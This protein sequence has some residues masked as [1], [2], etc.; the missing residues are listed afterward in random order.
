MHRT[1]RRGV[2]RRGTSKP[3]PAK[4]IKKGLYLYY[5]TSWPNSTVDIFFIKSI[6]VSATSLSR[7]SHLCKAVEIRNM[8]SLGTTELPFSPGEEPPEDAACGVFKPKTFKHSILHS[9]F[10]AKPTM[11]ETA[12]AVRLDESAAAS[13]TKASIP[14][15]EA[16]ARPTSGRCEASARALHARARWP[17]LC[18]SAMSCKR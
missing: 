11:A 6:A 14:P 4:G 7:G 3:T 9:S 13:S 8:A 1:A 5:G 2:H 15:V 16:V 10:T 17:Y 12:A 18:A